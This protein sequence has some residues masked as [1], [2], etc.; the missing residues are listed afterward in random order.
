[1]RRFL[2]QKKYYLALLAIMLV[3]ECMVNPTG[4]FPLNDDWSYAKPVKDWHETGIYN[5]G[6]WPAMTLLT[7]LLWGLL[8]VKAFGFSF[9]VLR[10]SPLLS[11]FVG[12]CAM[13]ALG[14]RISGSRP[15]GFVMA[16]TLL[17]NPIYFNLSNTYMTD[18]NF[19]TLLIVGCYCVYRFFEKPGVLVFIWVMGVSVLM[20]F[21]RQ[22]GFVLPLAFLVVLMLQKRWT[23]V[24]FTALGIALI[25]YGIAYMKISSVS[26]CRPMPV[27]NMLL[28]VIF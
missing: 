9:L 16:L 11:S 23:Y 22:F 21:M 24:L 3:F 18:V 28:T 15:I 13:L 1:M 7:H 25:V 2:E 20:V 10:I 17:L 4:E 6:S 19:S 5:I 26:S 12:L 27:I 8:F 14:Q